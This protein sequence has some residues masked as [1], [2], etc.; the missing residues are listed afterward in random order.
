MVRSMHHEELAEIRNKALEL[1]TRLLA[2]ARAE[3]AYRH[4]SVPSPGELLQWV[5]FSEDCE[6]LRPLTK[7]I[8]G[9]DEVLEKDA[10]TAADVAQA[11][12]AVERLASGDAL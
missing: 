4:G 11:R 8:A 12:S 5:A 6:W 3:Y 7:L 1:H 10:L 9:V 2:E